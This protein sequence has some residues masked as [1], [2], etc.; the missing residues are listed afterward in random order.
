MRSWRS[1]SAPSSGIVDVDRARA[2]ADLARLAPQF[3]LQALGRVEQLE[4]L[5]SSVST[6]RQALRKLAWSSTSPTGSV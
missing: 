3:P 5:K 4:R 6:R 1:S 2:V